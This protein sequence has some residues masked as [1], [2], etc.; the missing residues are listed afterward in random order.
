MSRQIH[1]YRELKQ[2]IH[3]DLRTQ[4]P[5]WIAPTG[6]CPECDEHEARLREVLDTLTRIAGDEGQDPTSL[7]TQ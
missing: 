3:Q 5:E 7:T 2:Q 6:E 4:H 1:S